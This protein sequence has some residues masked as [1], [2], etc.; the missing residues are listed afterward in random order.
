MSAPRVLFVCTGN[1]FRSPV[2]EALTRQRRPE[3]F[4][5]SAG[6]SVA[7]PIAEDARRYAAR[8][9]ALALMKSAPEPIAAKDLSHYD[10]IVAMEPRHR[11]AILARCADCVD[12]LVV[13]YVADP[14]DHVLGRV[15]LRCHVTTHDGKVLGHAAPHTCV[16]FRRRRSL[17]HPCV[18]S[19]W[20]RIC[21][22]G[23]CCPPQY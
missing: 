20:C 18:S 10:L 19:T 23:M 22:N 6:L 8:E 4:V 1:T 5:D 14:G 2:A 7:I 15:T 17:R 9:G 3:W 16:R 11:A 21:S 13:W 12:R